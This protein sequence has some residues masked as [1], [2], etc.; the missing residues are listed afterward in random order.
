MGSEYAKF[1][2]ACGIGTREKKTHVERGEKNALVI[3]DRKKIR[4]RDLPT[5][6]LF[7]L[8]DV[9]QY[10]VLAL[11]D[12]VCF[13]PSSLFPSPSSLLLLLPPP[14]SLL[15]PSSSLLPP[16]PPSSLLLAFP[17]FF[18]FLFKLYRSENLTQKWKSRHVIWI[19]NIPHPEMFFP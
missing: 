6:R 4:M 11:R 17:S 9:D 14:S 1:C 15:P 8:E 2:S 5:H 16:P 10:K 3:Y 12:K 18:S 19:S 7:F 13:Y